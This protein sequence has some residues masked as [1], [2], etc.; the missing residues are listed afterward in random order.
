MTWLLPKCNKGSDLYWHIS[1]PQ[2]G[3]SKL[4]QSLTFQRWEKT[5]CKSCLIFTKQNIAGIKTLGL[6]G[7]WA[8]FEA[9]F[10][11]FWGAKIFF[12]FFKKYFSNYIEKLHKMAFIIFFFWKSLKKLKK[13]ELSPQIFIFIANHFPA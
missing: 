2:V 10:V 13:L 6:V 12:L 4:L 5:D 7:L 8:T 9:V 1:L 3:D 11:M